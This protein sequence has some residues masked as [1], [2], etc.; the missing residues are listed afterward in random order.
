MPFGLQAGSCLPVPGPGFVPRVSRA[1]SQCGHKKT[2]DAIARF[3][4]Q[5]RTLSGALKSYQVQLKPARYAN[6]LVGALETDAEITDPL[7]YM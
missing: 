7:S 6:S 5:L 1:V 2:G 4:S 3:Y